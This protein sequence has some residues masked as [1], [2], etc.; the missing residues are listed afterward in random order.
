MLE[1]LT[2]RKEIRDLLIRFNR[3]EW[4]ILIPLL[5]ELGIS[6][7]RQDYYLD[8]LTLEDFSDIADKM[9]MSQTERK[10]I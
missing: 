4:D 3:N 8:D 1:V 2:K 5:V 7:I 6:L 9:K 10:S